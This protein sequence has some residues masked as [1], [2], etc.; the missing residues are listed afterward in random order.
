MKGNDYILKEELTMKGLVKGIVEI[1]GGLVLG[2][3]MS[4]GLNKVIEVSKKVVENKVKK[5][6]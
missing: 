3:L 6:S 5:E 1:A 4:D 2:G